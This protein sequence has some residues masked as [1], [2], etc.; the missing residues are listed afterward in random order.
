MCI[1]LIIPHSIQASKLSRG[2]TVSG[3]GNLLQVGVWGE[4]PNGLNNDKG[5]KSS[6]LFDA[7]EVKNHCHGH[8]D[9]NK[10]KYAPLI[11]KI[12]IKGKVKK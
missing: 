8:E 5:V 3:F 6:R 7:N 11:G 1:M 10:P 12:G 2:I 9:K 4:A